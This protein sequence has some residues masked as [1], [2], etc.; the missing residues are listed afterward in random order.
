MVSDPSLTAQSYWDSDASPAAPVIVPVRCLRE[1]NKVS[2]VESMPHCG[3]VHSKASS[4]YFRA[5]F[6]RR[7][8]SVRCLFL[9]HAVAK[10]GEEKAS[11]RSRFAL[12][13]KRGL[14]F[15]AFLKLEG[16]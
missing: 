9:T 6:L 14:V 5:F 10:P 3:C 12:P 11:L 8:C 1:V 2:R 7:H 16:T 4:V 15:E 13:T